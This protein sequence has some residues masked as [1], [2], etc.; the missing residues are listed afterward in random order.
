M[1]RVRS[2]VR[3]EV[4]DKSRNLSLKLD[5]ERFED[6]QSIVAWL[7]AHD[8]V[9]VCVVVHTDAEWL[10]WRDVRVR[11][12]VERRVER[13]KLR[14][15]MDGVQVLL[16]LADYFLVA[17]GVEIVEI[18]CVILVVLL[19]R[20]IEAVVRDT[21]FLTED[22]SLERLRRKVALHLTD[23]LLTKKLEVFEGGILL[24]IY[25]D[26]AHTVERLV[27]PLQVIGEIRG[28][29]LMLLF[30]RGDALLRLPNLV[31]SALDGVDE[32]RVHLVLVVQEPRAL[33]SLRHI[34][35]H[36]HTMIKTVM[37]EIRA[38]AT[39]GRERFVLQFVVVD[40]LRLVD[41][42]P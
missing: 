36:H 14:V 17:E 5:I 31:D 3:A 29:G 11:A 13:G 30:E 38:Y 22:R 7:T 1:V 8:P 41:K 4:G 2:V 10:H 23:V 28:N 26:R 20:R 37:P 42:Q 25:G 39:V 27:E 21:D 9:D 33:G 19:H 16:R 15:G 24:I 32:F 40:E 34:R 18:R 35:E 12:A 6:V